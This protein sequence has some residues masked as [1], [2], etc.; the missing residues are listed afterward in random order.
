MRATGKGSRDQEKGIGWPGQCD[1]RSNTRQHLISR[2]GE[3]SVIQWGVGAV[4]Q[5][6]SA[7]TLLL[8]TEITAKLYTIGL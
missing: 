4:L 8:P 3:S 2:P 5:A 7:P 1:W 6:E